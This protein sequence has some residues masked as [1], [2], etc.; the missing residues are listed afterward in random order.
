M[1]CSEPRRDGIVVTSDGAE[2]PR[3]EAEKVKAEWMLPRQGLSM[4]SLGECTANRN[5]PLLALE[6]Y[7]D[8]GC[9]INEK[10]TCYS[11]EKILSL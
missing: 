3:C 1:I 2:A 4:Q 6:G 11:S 8:Q 7:S 10:I 9:C 5:F